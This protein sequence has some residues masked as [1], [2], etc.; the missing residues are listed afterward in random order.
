MFEKLDSRIRRSQQA[1]DSSMMPPQ[2]FD[3]Q[4]QSTSS[5]SD[6]HQSKDL[7]VG[8]ESFGR[9]GRGGGGGGAMDKYGDGRCVAYPRTQSEMDSGRCS[10]QPSPFLA[11]CREPQEEHQRAVAGRTSRS[12]DTM[13]MRHRLHMPWAPARQHRFCAWI[14][15]R[16]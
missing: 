14:K 2:I 8:R 3:T 1:N 12:T 9:E 15:D 4:H 16:S 6:S 7:E 13:W 10:S 5:A 11:A